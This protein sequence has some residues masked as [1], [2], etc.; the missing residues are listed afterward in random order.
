[1]ASPEFSTHAISLGSELR[2]DN[3]LAHRLYTRQQ[4]PLTVLVRRSS[5]PQKQIAIDLFDEGEFRFELKPGRQTGFLKDAQIARKRRK[6]AENYE[7]FEMAARFANVI[8]SNPVSSESIDDSFEL[9]TKGLDSW[10][11]G[12]NSQATYLKCL[13]LYCRQEGYPVKEEWAARMPHADRSLT[14]RVLNHP[15]RDLQSDS[16]ELKNVFESL[17]LYMEHH[18]HIR[19]DSKNPS[20][21]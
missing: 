14:A 17:E 20:A 8:L 5:K 21:H 3:Y 10:E 2:G 16:I 19:I 9:L 4:G 15:L 11:A 18:T 7:A 1:M 12:M 13:Y 6:L